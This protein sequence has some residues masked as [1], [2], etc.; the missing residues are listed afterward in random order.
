M[1]LYVLC[2]AVVT[3]PAERRRVSLMQA[4]STIRK[5]KVAIRKEAAALFFFGDVLILVTSSVV[6]LART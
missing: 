1:C 2:R 5:G 3:E 4:L 6:S